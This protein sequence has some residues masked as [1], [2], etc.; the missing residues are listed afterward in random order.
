MKNHVITTEPEFS[1]FPVLPDIRVTVAQVSTPRDQIKDTKPEVDRSLQEE[2]CQTPLDDKNDERYTED[3]I[4]N[5]QTFS[6]SA[7]TFI[8]QLS[9]DNLNNDHMN[10]RQLTVSPNNGEE[11]TQTELN[12]EPQPSIKT[13]Y[14]KKK[15]KNDILKKKT[16]K[17]PSGTLLTK[18]VFQRGAS[19]IQDTYSV[20]PPIGSTSST[21]SS[22]RSTPP[23]L[24]TTNG[25]LLGTRSHSNQSETNKQK[26]DVSKDGFSV[27]K[28]SDTKVKEAKST[29][30]MAELRTP[31]VA[32]KVALRLTHANQ[33]KVVEFNHSENEKIKFRVSEYCQRHATPT[34]DKD[35]SNEKESGIDD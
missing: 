35:E 7:E 27:N 20:I 31:R 14:A 28:N 6:N 29:K 24:T 5:V 11:L 10:D 8:T 17:M 15:Q 33:D 19:H 25:R 26:S 4:A 13:T 1:A 22:R 16:S 30:D 34:E 12:T 23:P 2:K 9:S 18:P 32:R 21:T 3:K